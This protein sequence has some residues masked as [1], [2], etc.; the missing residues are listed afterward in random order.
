MLGRACLMH[1][2]TF[3]RYG[4][5]CVPGWHGTSGQHVGI[6]VATY[7]QST[8]PQL[9]IGHR[10]P[11]S[12]LTSTSPWSSFSL[13]LFSAGHAVAI[14]QSG[15]LTGRLSMSCER[16]FV[17]HDYLCQCEM[18]CGWSA[19]RGVTLHSCYIVSHLYHSVLDLQATNLNPAKVAERYTMANTQTTTEQ[20]ALRC[21]RLPQALI[22]TLIRSKGRAICEH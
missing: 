14:I 10:R 20:L 9:D 13:L 8:L 17:Q 2:T 21:A 22:L 7:R 19:A 4:R 12:P 16:F 1:R 3:E 5:S 6:V 11:S 18:L 15:V